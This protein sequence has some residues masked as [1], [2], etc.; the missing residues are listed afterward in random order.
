MKAMEGCGP[1]LE[2]FVKPSVIHVDEDEDGDERP[3]LELSTPP[4][5]ST[6]LLTLSAVSPMSP[7]VESRHA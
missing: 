6:L 1:R 2:V 7:C 5:P 3:D 4:P